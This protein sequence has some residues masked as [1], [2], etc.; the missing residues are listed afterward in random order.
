[1]KIKEILNTATMG[2]PKKFRPIIAWTMLEYLL[3][4]LPHGI[5]LFIIW[6]LFNVLENPEIGV[7]INAL[8]GASIAILIIMILLFFTSRKSYNER[9]YHGY[10]VSYQGRLRMA[11][12]LRKLP[13]GF[14]N[15]KDP[16]KIGAYL[17]NDYANI[18]YLCTHIIP[19][20]FGSVIGSVLLLTI[21]AT[22]SWKLA[23]AA[24]LVI[25]LALPFTKISYWLV[26]KF[27]HSQKQAK[28]DAQSRMLEYIYGMKYIKA[29][30]LTGKKF[31]KLAA[32]F[33]K[34][35]KE[36]IRLEGGA[37]PT[38]ILTGFI[39]NG[40]FTLIILLG[41]T[42]LLAGTVSIPIY[43][44]FLVLGS[45]VFDPIVQS[46]IFLGEMRYFNLGVS[47]IQNLLDEKVM[48]GKD[49]DS[50]I[51]NFSIEF[52]KVSFRYHEKDVLKEVTTKIPEKSFIALVGPSGS[53]KTTM[54]RLIARFW[55]VNSGC[56]RIGG[57]DIRTYEPD[58]LLKQI[59]VVFQEVY[60]FNDTILNNIK[61]GKLDAS[62]EEVK[63]AAIMARIDSFIEKLPN[64]YN[65]MVGEGG[66]TLSGG[67]KQR[68]SIAR[69]ILKDSPII[70]LDEATASLDPE[71]ELYIQK[72]I[73]TL[74]KDKTVII[75]AH[76][77]NTVVN[78]D[79]I[80]VLEEG[81]IVE[82]GDHASLY[83]NH[84]LYRH[85]WEEQSKTRN[86]KF[87]QN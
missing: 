18:E 76:R 42:F 10:E 22:M 36:S 32:S 77:L 27:G 24:F 73:D 5:A 62:I 54:T 69:A 82:Q 86:W 80:I 68:I 16:G 33:D 41:L 25:P 83:E 8:I 74:V 30:N 48:K 29:F 65:T 1:M 38:L 12:H 43:V 39:L 37:G 11:E 49:I 47:R 3:R 34:L 72:A 13:M 28:I 59:S 15:S 51:E 53:G 45:H 6:E 55:D 61:I 71:N 70:L 2:E 31:Q 85:L 81:K 57:K 14:F 67:E 21:L 26:N 84:H 63:K 75:I 58:K 66:A 60:L 17:I 7:N 46:I 64:G 78:A 87:I 56:I 9:Y 19:Q 35:K 44:A 79:K 20:I 40:G 50:D 52:D 4:G 23:L